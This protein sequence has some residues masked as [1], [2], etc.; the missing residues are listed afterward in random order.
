MMKNTTLMIGACV[1]LTLAMTRTTIGAQLVLSWEAPVT[2]TDQTAV[3]NLAGYRVYF[4]T[5]SGAYDDMI[6]V[7]NV[8]E[9][10]LTNLQVGQRYY[11]AVAAYTVDYTEGIISDEVVWDT[12]STISSS[13]FI[14]SVGTTP[15]DSPKQFT[16]TWPAKA[17]QAYLIEISRDMTHW[18]PASSGQLA[19]EQ[20]TQYAVSDG[21]LTFCDVDSCIETQMY[22][23][24]KTSA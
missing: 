10:A 23:R 19:E 15:Q 7:S 1:A 2:Q 3:T 21:Q 5:S 11:L 4:G 17:G 9:V 22:Y 14:I 8:L 6:Q 20:S 12:P 16:I 18:Q 24:V 13:N